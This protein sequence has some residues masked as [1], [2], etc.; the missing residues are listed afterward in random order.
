[1]FEKQKPFIAVKIKRFFDFYQ[2]HGSLL[3]KLTKQTVQTKNKIIVNCDAKGFFVFFVCALHIIWFSPL[4]VHCP[5][6]FIQNDDIKHS[7]MRGSFLLKEKNNKKKMFGVWLFL[8][9]INCIPL[10]TF[11][12]LNGI[13]YLSFFCCLLFWFKINLIYFCLCHFSYTFPYY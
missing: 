10:S 5:L 11:Y 2:N 12:S 4:N 1:M 13:K 8:L 6:W 3:G 9:L 7:Y